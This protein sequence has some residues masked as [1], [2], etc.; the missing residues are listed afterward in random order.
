MNKSEGTVYQ[1]VWNI[2]EAMLIGKFRTL[3]TCIKKEEIF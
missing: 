3:N 1:N 2:V